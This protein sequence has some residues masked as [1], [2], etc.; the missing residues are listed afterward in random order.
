[1]T[2]SFST[3]SYGQIGNIPDSLTS[4]SYNIPELQKIST[5]LVRANELEILYTIAENKICT[6][7][8]M[9]IIKNYQIEQDGVIINNQKSI[10]TGLAT[11]VKKL[12][13]RLNKV[14]VQKTWFKIGIGIA[15]VCLGGLIIYAIV[16]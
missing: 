1:M 11:D 5:K 9:I 12:N 15:S 13:L 6:L 4:V 14:E 8:S 2:L 10:I 7:D 16:K 3:V